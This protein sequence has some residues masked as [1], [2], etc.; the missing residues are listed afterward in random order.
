MA[1]PYGECMRCGFKRRLPELA[2]EWTGL[3]VCRDKCLDPRPAELRAPRYRP[4]GLPLPNASPQTVP[5]ERA[6][7]DKGDPNDL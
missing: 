5:V 3:R 2:K 6:P 1:A 7:G 4:E